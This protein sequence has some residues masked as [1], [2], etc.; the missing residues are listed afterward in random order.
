MESS[1]SNNNTIKNISAVELSNKL[2]D[3]IKELLQAGILAQKYI[4]NPN[5]DSELPNEDLEKLG[6]CVKTYK[7]IAKS[8]KEKGEY[9]IDK[10]ENKL[11]N[12]KENEDSKS[13]TEKDSKSTEEIIQRYQDL[14]EKHKYEMQRL[15]GLIKQTR[16]LQT[17]A[18]LLLSVDN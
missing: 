1:S 2:G 8:L 5:I 16:N 6:S 4:N 11:S 12:K 10:D 14:T 17:A 15:E 7:S 3:S 13:K 9:C 18:K